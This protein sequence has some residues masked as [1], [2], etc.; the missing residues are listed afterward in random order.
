[1]RAKVTLTDLDQA[2]VKGLSY[3][4][5]RATATSGIGTLARYQVCPPLNAHKNS[6]ALTTQSDAWK[7][8]TNWPNGLESAAAPPRCKSAVRIGRNR[9]RANDRPEG[10]LMT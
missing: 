8:L 2:V 10:E 1:M 9:Y 6:G 5:Q 4:H 3:L 7:S